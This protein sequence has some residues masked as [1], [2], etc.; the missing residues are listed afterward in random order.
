MAL[1]QLPYHE[2][3]AWENAPRGCLFDV[4]GAFYNM[5]ATGG[6]SGFFFC[7][8]RCLRQGG[9]A[10]TFSKAF[11]RVTFY[12]NQTR[13]LIFE[14][15]SARELRLLRHDAH[16][17]A[18]FQPAEFQPRRGTGPARYSLILILMVI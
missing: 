3:G 16:L 18:E 14:N 1:G 15:F 8:T 13:A 12:S 5:H 10:T 4:R 17:C 7:F 6:C 11:S 2:S 9:A